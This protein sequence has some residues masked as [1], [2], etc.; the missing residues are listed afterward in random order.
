MIEKEKLQLIPKVENYIQ[1]ELEMLLKL[2]RT[3]KYSI[4]TEYKESM[5]NTLEKVMFVNKINT[6]QKLTEK[7]EN[8]RKTILGINKIQNTNNLNKN[9]IGIY[10]TDNLE[11]ETLINLNRID[12]VKIDF[13]HE[14]VEML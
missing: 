7:A 14:N 1:Y 13:G 11:I 10:N 3:E 5:Y 2:P 8:K 9:I 6:I 12:G 4:G